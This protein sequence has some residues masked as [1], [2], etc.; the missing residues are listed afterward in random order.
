M[1]CPAFIAQSF[2]VRTAAHLIHLTTKSYAEHV[3]LD[4][5]YTGLVDLVDTFAELYLAEPETPSTV[6]PSTVPPKGTSVGILTSY[7]AD[8]REEMGDKPNQA[9]ANVL[10]EIEAL[11]LRTLYKL[12]NLK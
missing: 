6:F 1:S 11:T 4:E 5:F 8:V 7:L 3:A 10:A 9:M 2:A 12:K